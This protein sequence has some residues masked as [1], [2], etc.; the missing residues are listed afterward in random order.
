MF[1]VRDYGGND[2]LKNFLDVEVTLLL[3]LIG[4]GDFFRKRFKLRLLNRKNGD[5]FQELR[6][7][8]CG[9]DCCQPN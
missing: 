5:C 8:S 2:R 1:L 3:P 7:L 9:G 4:A 6:H